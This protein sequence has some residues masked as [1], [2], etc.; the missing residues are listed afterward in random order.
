MNR[1]EILKIVSKKEIDANFKKRCLATD[2]CLKCG[3]DLSTKLWDDGGCDYEC[4]TCGAKF[5]D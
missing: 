5:S 2:T 3:G 4:K 1:T